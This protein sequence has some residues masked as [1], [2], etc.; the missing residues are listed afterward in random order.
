MMPLVHSI[1]FWSSL[2]IPIQTIHGAR[3]SLQWETRMES[4]QSG[5]DGSHPCRWCFRQFGQ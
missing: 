4:D 1:I 2:E 5:V 3:W